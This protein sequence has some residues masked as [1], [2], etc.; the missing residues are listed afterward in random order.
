MKL[1][2]EILLGIIMFFPIV[3][4]NIK[5]IVTFVVYI[6][7]ITVCFI[8]NW[9][10]VA[11]ILMLPGILFFYFSEKIIIRKIIIRDKIRKKAWIYKCTIIN[12]EEIPDQNDAEHTIFTLTY[13]YF[14][15]GVKIQDELK[16]SINTSHIAY[17]HM[18]QL[19]GVKKLKYSVDDFKNA[20]KPGNFLYRN[21]SPKKNKNGYSLEFNQVMKEVMS[22]KNVWN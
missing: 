1:L 6:T 13:I 10:I 11:V 15:N 21:Y 16:F 9:H 19:Y 12:M 20:M 14:S 2:A 4:D 5:G 8:L 22:T 3:L 17:A 7:T 18:G